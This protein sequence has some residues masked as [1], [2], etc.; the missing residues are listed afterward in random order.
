MAEQISNSSKALKGMSSQ[1]VVTVVLAVV[2]IVSFSIMS[3]LLTK[4]DFGYYAAITAITTIFQSFSETGIGSAIVQRKDLTKHYINNAFTLS[5]IFA[6]SISS[7]LIVLSGPLSRTILDQ[8][9]QI[10]LML[11][12][13][14][15]F[16][17]CLTSVNISIMHR[18]L[19]FF[20]IGAIHL[21]SLIVTTI[22]AIVLALKGFGYY[23]ILAK[24]VLTSVL[25]LLLSKILC[26]Q[27]YGI[28]LDK[29]TFKSIFSFSGWL[30]ASS[31]FRNFAQQADRLLMGRLLSVA[32][33]GSYNRPK[34]FI[35]LAS[36]KFTGVFDSALFPVLSTIQDD[37]K[38]L[39]RAFKKSVYF[40][41]MLSMI[42]ALILVFGS[43]LI[44]RI[45]FGAE[46]LSLNSVFIVLS[47]V[48]IFD[49]D[50]RLSDCYFRSLGLTK[51]QF[52]FRILELVIKVTALLIGAQWDIMGV[53][54]SMLIASTFSV[55]LKV[56]YVCNKIDLG[57]VQ[58]IRTL[59]SSWKFTLV[60]LPVMVP[61]SLLLPNTWAGN[62][63]E[64][65]LFAV[66]IVLLFFFMPKFCGQLY[67]EEGYGKI[68]SFI[69]TKLKIGK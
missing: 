37:K 7:L 57:F 26:H 51:Q 29:A 68:M 15:L 59:F 48:V 52:Y 11:M 56:A 35:A 6:C 60:L 50:A 27:R 19:Q 13:I 25:T 43:E 67:Y 69:K 32:S 45:F 31:F 64:C 65:S 8:T 36:D 14:T 47:L 5:L 20:R 66:V 17:S 39:A 55:L 46:W 18:N 3:R 10:P 41:N 9:M 22:V 53:A 61:A 63:I 4:E 49:A 2:E 62:I 40:L 16:C 58:I 33:L 28:A 1:T 44:I 21:I 24:A 54:L 12:S 23:A 38:A 30:M 42:I 34:N